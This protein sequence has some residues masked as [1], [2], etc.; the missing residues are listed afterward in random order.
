MA[1]VM[2]TDDGSLDKLNRHMPSNETS[3]NLD[4]RIIIRIYTGGAGWR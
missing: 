3:R 2:C 4:V 1:D